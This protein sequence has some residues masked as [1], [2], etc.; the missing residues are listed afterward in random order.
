MYGL[1]LVWSLQKPE[2]LLKTWQA[3]RLVPLKFC[4]TQRTWLAIKLILLQVCQTLK[5]QKMK[6]KMCLEVTTTTNRSTLVKVV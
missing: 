1:S 4:R 3:V 2:H 5:H 6:E